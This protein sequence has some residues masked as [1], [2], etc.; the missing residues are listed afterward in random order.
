M[1]LIDGN[2]RGTAKLCQAFW[3]FKEIWLCTGTRKLLEML[4]A[5][6]KAET[7]NLR[8]HDLGFWLLNLFSMH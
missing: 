5:G 3:L 2:F 8:N 4:R 7:E 1:L 6:S